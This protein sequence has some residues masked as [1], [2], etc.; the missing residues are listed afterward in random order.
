[1]VRSMRMKL[2]AE[3]MVAALEDFLQL[4][5][6]TQL[7]SLYESFLVGHWLQAQGHY[8]NL[9]VAD[10]NAAVAAT[11]ALFP[12]H[13]LGRLAPFRFDWKVTEDSGRKTVWN[14]TTRSETLASSMFNA[15]SQGYGDIRQ[16]LV[17]G[18]A[19]I[20]QHELRAR[21][22][23]SWQ[24]LICLLLSQYDFAPTDDWQ[25]AKQ[26]MLG[27]LGLSSADLD[28]ITTNLSLG[29][30]LLSTTEWTSIDLPDHLRPPNPIESTPYH[31]STGSDVVIAIDNR[32]QRMLHLAV[33]SHT[34]VLLVGPPGTGKGTILRWLID[35]IAEDPTAFGFSGDLVPNPMW[36]TPDES[37]SSY[38]LV[39]ALMPDAI[40]QLRWSNGLVI[41]AIAE[42]RWLILDETNRADMDKIMG[43][44]LTWLSE[45]EVEIGRSEPHEGTPIILGWTDSQQSVVE[46]PYNTGRPTRFLAGQDWRFFGTYNPQDVQRVFRFG[47]ALSRRFA[48]VPI[49]AI[50]P[51]Q[52]EQLL[53]TRYSTLSADAID[54]VAALYSQHH[55][56]S[57]TLLGPAVFLRMVDYIMRAGESAHLDDVVAEAYVISLG[58]YLT[59]YDD[60]TFDEL[61]IRVRGATSLTSTHWS[62]IREQ[63]HLLS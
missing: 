34:C 31:T 5:Y 1:M 23:P 57:P 20:V 51:G 54:T 16:G 6:S 33:A 13:S 45:Q 43:P 41:D 8:P 4:Q 15:G 30:S 61:G 59:S 50:A 63:R 26:I 28:M 55:D 14:N 17:P 39:G 27:E 29:P 62:W 18:A 35:N 32:V 12:G 19:A 25:S 9:A 2:G 49:P 60:Q 11:F 40:G 58:Q 21:S 24:S 56:S 22:L 42:Q 36:R 3:A 7:A 10:A 47:L 53:A 37:W 52:F 38:E 44:L 46:D 48:V